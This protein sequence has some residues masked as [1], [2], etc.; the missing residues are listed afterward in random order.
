MKRLLLRSLFLLLLLVCAGAPSVLAQRVYVNDNAAPGGTGA[1]WATAFNTLQAA[2]ATSAT[3][4]WVAEG[5]YYPD[6]NG[7]T[8]S[9]LRTA[10][11]TIGTG[12][13]VY[14]GFEGTETSLSQRP[15]NS[16]AFAPTILDGDIDQAQST[17]VGDV[18]ASFDV[19]TFT[20]AGVLDGF[21][22]QGGNDDRT[23]S[24]TNA[25]GVAGGIL[26]T[27]TGT[28][29]IVRNSILRDNSALAPQGASISGLNAGY[30]L[31]NVLITNSGGNS[32]PGLVSAAA[33]V[34]SNLLDDAGNTH[35]VFMDNVTAAG[36]GGQFFKE[37]ENAAIILTVENSVIWGNAT[38]LPAGS[39]T[40]DE[41]NAVFT[42]VVWD[43]LDA[44]GGTIASTTNVIDTDP[45]LSTDGFFTPTAGSSALEHGDNTLL[46]ADADD[47]DGDANTTEAIPVDGALRER[48][49]S[50]NV[51]AGWAEGT[52]PITSVVPTAPEIQIAP[53]SVA[54]GNVVVAA[55]PA[56]NQ[57][58]VVT[59]Q[60]TEPLVVTGAALT[61]DADFTLVSG[62]GAFNL[63]PSQTRNIVIGFDPSSA[64]AK[65]AT[66]T[67]NSNDTS[68][69]SVAVAVTGT[70]TTEPEEPPIV[71]ET[72]SPSVDPGE[73]FEVDVR[74]GSTTR[75]VDSLFT[76][77][78]Q[79]NFDAA[80]LEALDVATG[81]FIDAP[82]LIRFENA[83]NGFLEL[84]FARRNGVSTD[85]TG[86]GD[87]ATIR[88]MV[89]PEARDIVGTNPS[90]MTPISLSDLS[91]F[92]SNEDPVVFIAEPETLNVGIGLRHFIWPG[93]T[94]NSTRVSLS[95]LFPIGDCYGLDVS[96]RAG[97]EPLF[98]APQDIRW[99]AQRAA[100]EAFPTPGPTESCVV[101]ATPNPAFAN[102]NGD[103]VI[104]QNDVLA[105]G[106]NYGKQQSIDPEDGRTPPALVANATVGALDAL[107][108]QPAPL[109]SIISVEVVVPA[110]HAVSNLF[111]AAV[112]LEVP[113][114]MFRI[115]DIRAG[116]LLEN[117]DL[118]SL[119]ISDVEN[120]FIRQAFTRKRGSAP[121]P[122]G[123]GVVMVVDLEVAAEMT[124]PVSVSL[125]ELEMNILGSGAEQA[126]FDEVVL[127]VGGEIVN[128][129]AQFSF[130]AYPNPVGVASTE[131][132]LEYE[133]AEQAEVNLNVYDVLGRK[134]QVLVNGQE[135]TPGRYPVTMDVSNLP[136]G[137]YFFR[138]QAGSFVKTITIQVVR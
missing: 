136:A 133:L 11:F 105:V 4:I 12:R 68:E 1:S 137:P 22:V 27:S 74:V 101:A 97:V 111:G 51:D 71:L 39:Q 5:T 103:I 126:A 91:A 90:Y 85:A 28:G 9:N 123:S 78:F 87:V 100:S 98:E 41:P 52:D 32:D 132:T 31:Q 84:A 53:L 72:V 48:V 36:N 127:Q 131:L 89:K 76:I 83:G 107:M 20:G 116:E 33:G 50:A 45:L 113:A 99:F 124:A 125:S 23:L 69:P 93:D 94:D 112:T 96:S 82:Q 121:A 56:A 37:S 120:G 106:N 55:G 59:N 109:G 7:A 104:N 24:A 18:T 81:P 30:I 46:P 58:V 21:I 35:N 3:E 29:A 119:D 62:G 2:L 95:D 73:I 61:G 47:L 80:V 44:E 19:V 42:D 66:L 92:T 135:Q 25:N 57:T 115:R 34:R 26:V 122:V 38:S 134:I 67:I 16:F 138:L 75:P 54:F 70:G 17:S 86:T 108:L 77:G 14:G 60:G 8:D 40:L 128:P 102:A 129:P 13:K 110:S 10:T 118:L 6:V 88:F 117:D 43:R 63:D 114:S 79:V 65:T 130:T 49:L 15:T 64:G